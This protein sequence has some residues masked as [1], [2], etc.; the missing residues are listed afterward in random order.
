MRQTDSQPDLRR[1]RM[2]IRDDAGKDDAERLEGAD[3]NEIDGEG[4]NDHDPPPVLQEHFRFHV[5]L[6]ASFASCLFL[7]FLSSHLQL[8][9]M[10]V[11]LMFKRL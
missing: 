10:A 4:T 2:E 6:I 5:I 3:V 8:L 1:G 7:F 11:N 9:I